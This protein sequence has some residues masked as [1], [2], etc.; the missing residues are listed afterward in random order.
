M[1]VSATGA[2]RAGATMNPEKV[3]KTPKAATVVPAA[4]R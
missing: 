2:H 3:T 4:T 1:A